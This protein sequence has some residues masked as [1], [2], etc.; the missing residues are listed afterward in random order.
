[1]FGKWWGRKSIQQDNKY[2]QRFFIN[3]AEI[4]KDG[5]LTPL[6]KEMVLK[7]LEIERGTDESIMRR[8]KNK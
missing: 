1:M 3:A 7:A 4:S 2:R 5:Y 6:Q 8:N